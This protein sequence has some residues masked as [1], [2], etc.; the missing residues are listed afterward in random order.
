MALEILVH[1]PDGTP[2]SDLSYLVDED[3]GANHTICDL[4]GS[5]GTQYYVYRDGIFVDVY[6]TDANNRI[7]FST[8]IGGAYHIIGVPQEEGDT[9]PPYVDQNYPADSSVDLPINT[10]SISCHIKDLG[11]GVNVS[12]IEM[13]VNGIL[14]SP[15]ITGSS[16]DYVVTYLLDSDLE[17]D[18][19][20]LV[21]V[22]ASDLAMNSMPQ[23]LWSFQTES[24][25]DI[26]APYVEERSPADEE[27]G[28]S[29]DA[30]I[31]CHVKDD[32]HGVD[33]NSIVMRVNGV[34]VTPVISGTPA[35]YAVT[36]LPES[37][38]RYNTVYT[39]TVDAD[40]L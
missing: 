21:T 1:S 5:E 6:S 25:P 40:D 9:S 22:D 11:D 34:I 12:T 35:D 38:L 26:V 20:Y 27:I 18:T 4:A 39:I 17:Y 28:V 14:V 2:M 3:G 16:D 23:V 15:E 31:S 36:Y 7:T 33:V 13:T 29:V 30:A 37:P 24:D 32:W 8:S 10:N 19:V